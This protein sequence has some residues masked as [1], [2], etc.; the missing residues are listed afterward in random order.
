MNDE[1]ELIE[2]PRWVLQL[3]LSKLEC[4]DDRGPYYESWQSEEL[5]AVIANIRLALS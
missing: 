2:V 3:A 4:Y 5:K 1:D